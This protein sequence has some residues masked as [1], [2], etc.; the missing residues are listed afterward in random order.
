MTI[1]GGGD[2][3]ASLL[4]VGAGKMGRA[5][6]QGWLK[7]GLDPARVR[8]LDPSP[9]AEVQ[10]FCAAQGVKFGAPASPPDVLV[11]AIKPQSLASAAPGLTALAGPATLVISILA[12]KTLKSLAEHLPAAGAFVRAMPNLPAAIGLGISGAV[13]DPAVTPAQRQ[14]AQAL[15]A[16]GGRVE[17]LGAEDL[18]DAVTAV[19]GSGPAYVFYLA[20][21]L[22]EAGVAQGLPPTVA[23]QLA[24]ATIEGAGALLAAFPEVSAAKLRADVTS[25][26]GTTA[27]AL[28]ELQGE[29]ALAK[30]IDRAVAAARKRAQQLS[31]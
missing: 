21:C 2:F 24:R 28:A 8:I 23:A 1:S 3:P 16:A 15:L 29:A 14:M 20:E 5:L 4:L 19:S 10:A 26:G 18:I 7:L 17:W 11:L 13:A 22:A 31:G 27:A 30:L 25:P 12:G 9:S 6:L